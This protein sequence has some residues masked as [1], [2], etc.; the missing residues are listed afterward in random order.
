MDDDL[1]A[2]IAVTD[3]GMYEEEDSELH[4]HMKELHDISADTEE[5][6]ETTAEPTEKDVMLD[7]DHIKVEDIVDIVAP[8]IS[9]AKAILNEDEQHHF[10][11]DDSTRVLHTLEPPVKKQIVIP[12][13]IYEAAEEVDD[14]EE[15]Q[16]YGKTLPNSDEAE[17]A[18][19]QLESMNTCR[20]GRPKG[21]TAT[22]KA[23]CIDQ[24]TTENNGKLQSPRLPSSSSSSSSSST[25][26]AAGKA[27]I[28]SNIL[29]P[30]KDLTITTGVGSS[31]TPK[32]LNKSALLS[33]SDTLDS[34]TTPIKRVSGGG[35]GSIE[36]PKEL[37]LDGP[38]D[39]LHAKLEYSGNSSVS[40]KNE[41]LIA[42]LEGSDDAE[43]SLSPA[44][45]M[46]REMEKKIAFEQINS[47]PAKPRGRR[48][49]DPAAATNKVVANKA[50]QQTK[51]FIHSLVSE[52][53]ESDSESVG[54]QPTTTTTTTTKNEP[55][56]IVIT[57]TSASAAP[58]VVPAAITVTKKTVATVAPILN[59]NVQIEPKRSRIIK[60]KIIWDPDAPE[61]A[62][63]YASLVQPAGAAAAA[64]T[65]K[66]PLAAAPKILNKRAPQASPSEI[67]DARKKRAT[68][69]A[70]PSGQKKRKISEIDKLLGDEGAINMLNALKQEN[71]TSGAADDEPRSG[72]GKLRMP[73]VSPEMT[74]QLNKVP[75]VMVTK[76]PPTP[77]KSTTKKESP[78]TAVQKRKRAA[79]G[80]DSWDYIYSK[81]D[82]DALIIRR[83]S[84]SSYSSTTSPTRLSLDARSDDV[85]VEPSPPPTKKPTVKSVKSFEFAKPTAKKMTGSSVVT[86]SIVMDIEGGVSPKQAAATKAAAVAAAGNATRR[87]ARATTIS[88][89][90]AAST[91]A[92]VELTAKER[93]AIQK[94]EMEIEEA[95]RKSAVAADAAA[96]SLEEVRVERPIL[97]VA[98]IIL[99]PQNTK[100]TNVFTI[101]VRNHFFVFSLY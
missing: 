37:I 46:D 66:R 78:T 52:W 32:I 81:R 63:S 36:I 7:V 10:S 3:D 25:S 41:D 12:V 83:R 49:K 6:I 94:S 57:V 95:K 42:I 9:P 75:R 59:K 58:I 69:S 2:P 84:N 45:I 68:D 30:Q 97:T 60:K 101:P 26:S 99:S 90:P 22:K 24:P 38:A 35:G 1:V 54:D 23:R 79:A 64:T 34:K 48:P 76:R 47:F 13:K 28:L 50:K 16:K 92:K 87:S 73:K 5:I 62:I 71:N 91:T 31:S 8:P 55:P 4:L 67:A 18:R 61:T 29:L 88:E 40:I 39:E 93:R 86:H 21:Y 100:L 98:H 85:V 82:E 15:E 72:G 43:R 77:Q 33:L 19:K 80:S 44:T 74:A 51:D 56:P 14:D 20:V 11:E 89:G 17:L 53:G 65:S 70:S 96:E 27:L